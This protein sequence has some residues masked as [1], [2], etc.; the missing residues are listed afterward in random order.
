MGRTGIMSDGY[1]NREEATKAMHWFDEDGRLFYRSGDV[2]YLDERGFTLEGAKT[3]LKNNKKT[4]KKNEEIVRKLES[5][6]QQLIHLK[7][8]LK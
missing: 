1:L 3:E 6:K 4:Y 8:S 5:I 7:D 2:G